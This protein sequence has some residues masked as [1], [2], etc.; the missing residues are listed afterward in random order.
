MVKTSKAPRGYYSASQA[1]SRLGIGNSTFY[2]FVEV[3]KIRRTVLPHM[4]EG[5]YS[6]E[7][8]D[9]LAEEREVS[10]QI[11]HKEK[12]SILNEQDSRTIPERLETI[13]QQLNEYKTL[14]SQILEHLQKNADR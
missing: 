14:L 3:G 13:E 5:Y 8:I 11:T 9:K 1:M 4:K 6:Q 12:S 2:H 10:I 7:D